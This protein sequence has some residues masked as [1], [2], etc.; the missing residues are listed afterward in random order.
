M[1]SVVGNQSEKVR[2]F[3]AELNTDSTV[4][5]TI[6]SENGSILKNYER[7]TRIDPFFQLD[8]YFEKDKWYLL[9]FE[10]GLTQEK[11][12]SVKSGDPLEKIWIKSPKTGQVYKGKITDENLVSIYDGTCIETAFGFYYFPINIPPIELNKKYFFYFEDADV[13][14]FTIIAEKETTIIKRKEGGDYVD[15]PRRKLLRVTRLEQK[16]LE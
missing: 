16:D 9:K 5:I 10:F 13:A 2:F 1:I 6:Y 15:R 12:D 8:F 11:Y 14:P 4:F 7:M 3:N